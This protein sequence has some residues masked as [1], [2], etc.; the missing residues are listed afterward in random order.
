MADAVI[1]RAHVMDGLIDP[2]FADEVR[3]GL[4]LRAKIESFLNE[5]RAYEDV[6][7]RARII[8]QEQMFLISAGL[9]AGVVD[10]TRA[11][12]QFT[13]LAETLLRR[14]FASVRHEFAQRHG[15]VRGARAALLA[16]GKLASREM[17]ARSDLDLIMLYD[18]EAEE[19]EGLKPLPTSQYFA[20]LTQRLIAAVSA[21]TSEG[22]LYETD[23]R[24]RPSGNAGPVATSFKS[25]MQYQREGAWTWERLALTRARVVVADAGFDLIIDGGIDHV[26]SEPRD[27]ATTIGETLDMRARLARERPPRHPF[28]LKLAAGGLIDLEFIAQ[29]ARLVARER[30]AAP[31]APTAGT[32]A[33]MGE[34]GLLPQA[35][36][37]VAIHA[38]Y[39]TA[40]QVMSAALA[41]PFKDEGWTTSFREL[42]ATL[43]N[44][45]TF[46][47]LGD[48][49]RSMQTEVQAAAAGWYEHAKGLG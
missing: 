6:I 46:E 31:H 11:G 12:E 43:T 44:Y 24:L 49:L 8:G 30:I 2:A 36:R 48:D 40:L 5:A 4:L 39:S 45:P 26:L 35:E 3:R 22:V 29:S 34:A 18:A 10:A 17:T 32:L 38:T 15:R 25:F 27:V 33:R 14:V 23:M 47:R 7:D 13:T 42:L 41:N 9:L 21:P 37:L 1:H 19:S 28:D 20:R 16:F